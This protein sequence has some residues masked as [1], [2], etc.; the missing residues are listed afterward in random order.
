M[1]SL[2]IL[3]VPSVQKKGTPTISINKNDSKVASKVFDAKAFKQVKKIN[4]ELMKNI[5][6]DDVIRSKNIPLPLLNK[7]RDKY[8]ILKAY[9]LNQSNFST[10]IENMPA[11]IPFSLNKIVL[12]DNS[13]SD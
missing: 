1:K 11:L 9:H 4:K 7:L 3:L 5:F 12:E 13:L 6:V 8:L 2:D 10:F